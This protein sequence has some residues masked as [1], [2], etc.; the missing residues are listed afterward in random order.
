MHKNNG[1]AVSRRRLPLRALAALWVCS[2]ARALLRLLG[3]GGTS[4]PGQLAVKLCPDLLGR[5]AEGVSVIVVSGT[6]GK[7][8]TCRML[9]QAYIHAGRNYFAN[10]SGANLLPGITAEFAAHTTLSGQPRCTHAIIECDEM[11][12]RTVY[13]LLRP[14]IVVLTNVFRDQLDRYGEVTHTVDALRTAVIRSPEALLCLNADD[15]LISSIPEGLPNPLRWYGVSAPFYD[16]TVNDPSDAKY[17]IRCHAPYTYRYVTLGHL[18]DFCCP[19]CGYQRHAPD[20]S[21][22][23]VA[24]KATGSQMELDLYGTRYPVSLPIPGAFNVYNAAAAAAALDAAG[25]APEEITEA[26]EKCHCGFGRME[27]FD[28]GAGTQMMLVKNPTGCNQVLHYLGSL[29]EPFSLVLCLNDRAAD[30]TDISWIWD[31]DYESLAPCAKN[32]RE[33]WLSGDRAE[34]LLVRLKYAGVQAE[35]ISVTHDYAKLVE[36]LAVQS[37]PVFIVPTYTAMME[38]RPLLVKTAGGKAFWE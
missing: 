29:T 2:A 3:R 32:I 34:E 14:E 35:R 4:L 17:C 33:I 21:A 30:G 5:L 28:L 27:L 7:T 11:A 22:A 19:R 31:A 20:V 1:S 38:L 24:G 23:L 12:A 16:T 15:S 8:T 10:R 26:L 9:E 18:G 37:V 36:T 13:P 25:F 6:N